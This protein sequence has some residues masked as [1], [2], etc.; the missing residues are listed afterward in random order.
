L[1][2]LRCVE[3]AE[4]PAADNGMRSNGFGNELLIEFVLFI[5]EIFLELLF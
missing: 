1:P 2:Q 4:A 5:V 3:T